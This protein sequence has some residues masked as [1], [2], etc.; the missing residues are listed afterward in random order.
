MLNLRGINFGN[1]LLASG[2]ANFF[3]Q[4][5]W[6]FRK[7]VQLIPGANDDGA[8]HA[9][10]T[11]VLLSRKGNMK[12]EKNLQ[13]KEWFP[14]CI[15]IYWRQRFVMNAVGLSGPGF[16]ALLEAGLWQQM[17]KPFLISIMAV[18]D[19][20][21]ERLK[22]I[23]A[24]ALLLKIHKPEFLA[25]FGIEL[26]GSC[27]NTRHCPLSL[28]DGLIQQGGQARVADVPNIVKI[29]VLT[30]FETI[31]RIIRSGVF[32]ALLFSNTIKF[33]QLPE[34][35]SWD[36]LFKSG[37]SPLAEFGGGAYS[38][39]HAIFAV[40]DLLRRIEEAGLRIP[41][42]AGNGILYPHDVN[43][44]CKASPNNLKAIDYGSLRLL[45][46]WNEKRVIRRANELLGGR[47]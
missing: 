15:R 13:P 23:R 36:K 29:N 40:A 26:N 37:R 47:Y 11:S 33:G 9:S 34:W 25:P 5:P 2:A 10:K 44:L 16:E 22:E 39:W 38:G 45:R 19:A 12:L 31:S 42:V 43:F 18:G 24:M 6:W 20:L 46:P 17:P 14:K 30:P 35:I 28:A 4:R 3:K 1:A 27:P 21:E 8:T 7:Y 41:I 32:D